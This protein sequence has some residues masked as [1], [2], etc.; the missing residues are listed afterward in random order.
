MMAHDGLVILGVVVSWLQL[1]A[2]AGTLKD[3]FMWAQDG[4]TC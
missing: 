1:I 2:S 3:P 4:T